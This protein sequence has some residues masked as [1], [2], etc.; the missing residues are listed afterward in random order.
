MSAYTVDRGHIAYL[1]EA[2]RLWST[3]RSPLRWGPSWA[4]SFEGTGSGKV[5]SQRNAAEVGQML[6]DEN[7]RSVEHR[8]AGGVSADE[9]VRYTEHVVPTG[10][11]E[12]DP[13]QVIAA[14]NCF[15]Y[16][17]CETEDWETSEAYSYIE[18]LKGM[19]I[20]RLPGVASARWGAPESWSDA[21]SASDEPKNEEVK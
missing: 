19:A 1:V 6:S 17:A 3:A 4:C 14:C 16:Q 20:S 21:L 18:A 8:Y 15:A 9:I 10:L 12:P 13:A 7:V 5:G 11:P 2:G